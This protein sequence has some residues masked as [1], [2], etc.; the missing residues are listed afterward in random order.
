MCE[1]CEYSVADCGR[2]GGGTRARV[3]E[4]EREA[5]SHRAVSTHSMMFVFKLI[6]FPR[7][8]V[9]RV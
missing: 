1:C 3:K 9:G 6:R 4:E 2:M 5:Q 8:H 7:V